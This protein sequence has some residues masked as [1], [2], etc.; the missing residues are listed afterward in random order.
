VVKIRGM[1][2]SQENVN[3]SPAR[4]GRSEVGSVT[5]EYMH[6]PRSS[7]LHPLSRATAQVPHRANSRCKGE[8]ANAVASM[9]IKQQVVVE[10][11]TSRR[12]MAFHTLQA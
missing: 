5:V 1:G 2:D 3:D 9:R 6:G 11:S 4:L 7:C 12:R 10:G 8:I